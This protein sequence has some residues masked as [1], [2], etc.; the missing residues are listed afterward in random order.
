MKKLFPVLVILIAALVYFLFQSPPDTDQ[1][2]ITGLPWQIELLANGHVR[3]FGIEL[4]KDTLG[5]VKTV[6]GD[7][8]ELAIISPDNEKAGLEIYYRNFKAGILSGKL[9]VVAD[10]DQTRLLAMR[11]RGVRKGG[12]NRFRLHPDDFPA[13]WSTK[14]KS[15]TFIPL[16][17]LDQEVAI[18]RF[19]KPSEIIAD[20]N[21]TH[22]LYSKKGLDIILYKKG[23]DVL[24]YVAPK[25]FASLRAP[26]GSLQ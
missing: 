18:L 4:G 12:E 7:D 6:L 23:K 1:R 8:V 9:V 24:Q 2:K 14:V 5:N 11:S 17:K 10:M 25:D 13:V 20:K 15:L 19:G 21:M 16:V 3:V 26:L 22:L